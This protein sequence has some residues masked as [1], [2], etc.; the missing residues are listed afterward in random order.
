MKEGMESY[1]WV[2]LID[3]ECMKMYGKKHH[4]R[5]PSQRSSSGHELSLTEKPV[6]RGYEFERIQSKRKWLWVKSLIRTES[7]DMTV[8]W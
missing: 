3:K 7:S 6:K 5:S 4:L 8:T 1:T 2:T